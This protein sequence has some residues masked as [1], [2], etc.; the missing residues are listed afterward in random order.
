MAKKNKAGA[1]IRGKLNAF[2]KS[3]LRKAFIAIDKD[4]S[5]VQEA[6]AKFDVSTNTI[7]YHVK[8]GTFTSAQA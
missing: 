3:T 4:K 5:T 6:A 7:R 2:K 8:R 1:P